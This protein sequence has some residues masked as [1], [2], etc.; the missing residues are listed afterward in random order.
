MRENK[1]EDILAT[2]LFAN[3][4]KWWAQSGRSGAPVIAEKSNNVV[5]NLI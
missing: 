2:W 5:R 4:N 3:G 1:T